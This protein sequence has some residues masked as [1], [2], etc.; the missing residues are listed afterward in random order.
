MNK[1][2]KKFS[3]KIYYHKDAYYY[4]KK[5]EGR[6]IPSPNQHL[7]PLKRKSIFSDTIWRNSSGH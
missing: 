5:I 6:L 3:H 4:D 2:L 7:L 1:G